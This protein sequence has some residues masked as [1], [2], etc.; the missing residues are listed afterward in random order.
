MVSRYKGW[1]F[2][3]KWMSR[4]GIGPVPLWT[5][6]WLFDLVDRLK[7][8]SRGHVDENNSNDVDFRFE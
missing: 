8:Q 3:N 2:Q 5:V 6:G 1:I 7:G 4:H